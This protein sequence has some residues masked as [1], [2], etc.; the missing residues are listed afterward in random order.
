[1]A[2]RHDIK[3]QI[4]MIFGGGTVNSNI[5]FVVDANMDVTVGIYLNQRM[6]LFV[7]RCILTSEFIE[8]L[9]LFQNSYHSLM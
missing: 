7:S 6:Y 8:V 2:C 9:V 1:M 4:Y 3:I 5:Y